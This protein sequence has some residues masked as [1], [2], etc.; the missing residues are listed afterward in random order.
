MAYLIVLHNSAVFDRRDLTRPLTIGRS[1]DCD[2]V[3]PDLKASRRHCVVEPAPDGGWRVRDLGSRNGTLKGDELITESPLSGG[4]LLW[5]GESTC[6]QFGEGEM[7]RRRPRHPHEALELAR[8]SADEEEKR[9]PEPPTGPRPM[10]R[11]WD[12]DSESSPADSSA[13]STD[14]NFGK[15]PAA[16]A[17]HAARAT[18][19]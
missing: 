3:I 19:R 18:S 6:L 16:S 12:S 5:L 11:A 4:D 15:R 10:P 2:V 8:D 7:P 1:H 17:P 9:S 13:V 14:L